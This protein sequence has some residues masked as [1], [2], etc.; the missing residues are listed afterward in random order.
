Y[1]TL[2]MEFTLPLALYRDYLQQPCDAANACAALQQLRQQMRFFSSDNSNPE[3]I[4]WEIAQQQPLRFAPEVVF[5]LGSYYFVGTEVGEADYSLSLLTAISQTLWQGGVLRAEWET[6]FTHTDDFEDGRW[7]TPYRRRSGW[8]EAMLHQTFRPLA[9]LYNMTSIGHY[10]HSYNALFNTTRWTNADGKHR[11][12]ARFGSLKHQ[13]EGNDVNTWDYSYRYYLEPLNVALG[14]AYSK[15]ILEDEG[16]TFSLVRSFGDSSIILFYKKTVEKLGGIAI[17]IPFATRRSMTPRPYQF[18][19]QERWMAGL[20]TTM[21]TESGM[22]ILLP[23]HGIVPLTGHRLER[24]YFN[25][26]EMSPAHLLHNL[27]RLR[28][29]ASLIVDSQAVK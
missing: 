23:D 7:Y 13:G 26:D 29:A 22:N 5:S 25:S 19:T 15:H 1:Q 8:S 12:R 18:R 10:A 28:E 9:N 16:P 20:Q 4:Q 24:Q 11:L 3:P 27:P 17:Q 14:A 6:P 2:V 21:D